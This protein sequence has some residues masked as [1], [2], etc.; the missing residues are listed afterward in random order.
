METVKNTIGFLLLH[1]PLS[2]IIVIVIAAVLMIKWKIKKVI[3][4]VIIA[5][6]VSITVIYLFGPFTKGPHTTFTWKH[7]VNAETI[8][9][10][11]IDSAM[12]MCK[13]YFYSR[14]Q[15]KYCWLQELRF[16]DNYKKYSDNQETLTI[17]SR[18]KSGFKASADYTGWH[19][20]LEREN[21]GK[22]L[23]TR[24]GGG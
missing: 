6:A 16:N 1:L 13:E 20:T 18:I 10:E 9:E 23:V 7:I 5:V 19:F 14:D 4:K 15:F 11:D 22:W 21:N 12:E 2:A 8:S 3:L 17:D 24:V